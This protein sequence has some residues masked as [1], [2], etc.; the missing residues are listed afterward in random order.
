MYPSSARAASGCALQAV[1]APENTVSVWISGGS[2]PSTSMPGRF[3]QLGE[4][5]ESERGAPVGDQRTDR[6]TGRRHD[7]PVAD[8]LEHAPALEKLLQV[9]AAWPGRI[10]QRRCSLH[11]ATHRRLVGDVRVRG[12]GRARPW[13]SPERTRSTRLPASNRRSADQLVDRIAREHDDV[14]RFARLDALRDIDAARGLGDDLAARSRVRTA[15]RARRAPRAWPSRKESQ[16]RVLHWTSSYCA[17]GNRSPAH[18]DRAAT[19][20]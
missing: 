18:R 5:L 11:R 10:T 13:R 16:R 15:P 12:T 2:G 19:S 17:S 3:M 14:D 20:A 6:H 8:R 1:T 4:L 7:D 9:D